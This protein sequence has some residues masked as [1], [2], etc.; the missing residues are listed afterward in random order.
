[1]ENVAVCASKRS[2]K[3]LSL[4]CKSAQQFVHI[5]PLYRMGWFSRVHQ[6]YLRLWRYGM[7]CTL[8]LLCRMKLHLEIYFQPSSFDFFRIAA[9]PADGIP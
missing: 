5:A 8:N 2:R 1:M 6:A 9:N 3:T 7:Y 4:A